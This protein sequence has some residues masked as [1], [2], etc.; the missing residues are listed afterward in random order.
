MQLAPKRCNNECSLLC[1]YAREWQNKLKELQDTKAAA[2]ALLNK[3]RSPHKE[4]NNN[5]SDSATSSPLPLPLSLVPPS[6]SSS[7]PIVSIT[8]SL[9]INGRPKSVHTKSPPS[10]KSSSSPIKM[11]SNGAL[12]LAASSSSSGPSSPTDFSASS[13]SLVTSADTSQQQPPRRSPGGGR[14][15]TSYPASSG[16]RATGGSSFGVEICVVCGDR[17]SGE[18]KSKIFIKY[19]VRLH[20]NAKN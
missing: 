15:P 9:S 17:A 2:A 16:T 5:I 8:P 7:T 1:S 6:S 10:R 13:T 19:H 12:N 11:D 3:H 18:S 14:S 4:G 20:A